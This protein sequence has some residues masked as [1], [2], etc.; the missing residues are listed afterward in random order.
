[1]TTGWGRGSFK[2]ESFDL[3]ASTTCQSLP[4]YPLDVDSATGAFVSSRVVIC[5]GFE[6]STTSQCYSLGQNETEWKPSGNMTALRHGAAS[7]EINNKLVIFGGYYN[8]HLQSTEEFNEETGTATAGPNMPLAVR[9]H[10][11]VKLNSTTALIIGG[12]GY[13]IA[14]TQRGYLR[15]TYFY[16]ANMKSFTPG[17][18]LNDGRE[19]HACSILNTGTESYVVITGGSN[20][21]HL[22]S[23]EFMDVNEPTIWKTGE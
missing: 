22:D 11:A 12:S 14:G 3:A 18:L 6:F 17:P 13:E 16:D 1:M 4:D 21:A 7:V 23:T 2:T 19:K 10:C 8:G 20:R 9:E 15:S 5:G